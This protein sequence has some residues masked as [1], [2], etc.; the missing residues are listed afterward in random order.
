MSVKDLLGLPVWTS[1]ALK[2]LPPQ[3]IALCYHDVRPDDAPDSWLR[4]SY[5]D[6]AAQLDFLGR[7]GCFISPA[8]LLEP[9]GL[10][11][12]LNFLVT[13]DDG[14]VNNLEL[15]LPLLERASAPALFF[16]STYHA[17]SGESFWFDRV[18]LPVQAGR[19]HELD[20]REVGLRVY[21]FASGDAAQRWEDIERLLADIK[22]LGNEEESP[23]VRVLDHLRGRY[24]DVLEQHL[25]G[26][27]PMD[28]S[29]LRRLQAHPLATLGSHG[30]RHRIMTRRDD[31]DLTR[32]LALSRDWLRDLTG[33]P[34][35]HLAY[36]NGDAGERVRRICGEAGFCWGYTT[37]SGLLDLGGDHM[38]LHRVMVGGYDS[39]ALLRYKF[40]RLLLARLMGR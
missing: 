12:G 11:P 8:D 19:L 32:D 24:G 40:N 21:S 6:F 15:A 33:E 31:G 27:R 16:I 34:P 22:A 20:L 9:Q 39:Q 17:R 36:P 4:V 38:D 2:L 23:V 3:V 14:Y 13:F 25:P 30:H 7:L 10:R 29:Q 5:S 26:C 18:I 35:Q 37:R 28:Q 1:L